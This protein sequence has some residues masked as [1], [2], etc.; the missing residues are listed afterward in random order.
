MT[1][2]R[3]STIMA[4][5]AAALLLAA[6]RLP[7]EDKPAKDDNAKA[8]KI[9]QDALDS[10]SVKVPPTAIT[11]EAVTRAFPDHSFFAVVF[12]QYPVAIAPPEPFKS[13]NVFVVLPDGKLLHMTDTKELEKFFKNNLKAVKDDD[14]AKQAAQ[15]WLVVSE[16][17]QQDGFFKFSVPK[18]DLKATEEKGERK[19]TGKFVVTQGGKGELTAKLVFDDKGKLTNVSED[20]AIKPGVR[21]I[22]QATKLLDP[23]PLVRRMA[24]QDILVMGRACKGYL[25][26]QRA[27]ASP[28]LRIAI[29][30]IWQKIVEEGW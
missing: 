20:N 18:D 13:R 2:A 27:K 21:P 23:D 14:S 11:D 15:A 26:E 9:V 28:E 4:C 1:F 25:D 29:D 7:A 5:A 22:C 24:E 8:Q 12:R 30:R 17:F 16:T 6:I 3:L 19:A 10:K